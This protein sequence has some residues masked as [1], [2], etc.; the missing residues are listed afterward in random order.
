VV[1]AQETIVQ[2]AGDGAKGLEGLVQVLQENAVATARMA[3]AVA[4]AN[5]EG[6]K[7]LMGKM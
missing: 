7:G 5:L 2:S 4:D 1:G 3:K 6:A